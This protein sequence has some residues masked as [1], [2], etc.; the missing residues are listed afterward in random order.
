V[1]VTDWGIQNSLALL[2]KGSLRMEI[3][4]GDFNKDDVGQ[5]ERE[6]IAKMAADRNAI[7]V[8]HVAGEEVFRGSRERVSRAAENAGLRKQV[9]QIIADSHG[10][11]AFEIF[12]WAPPANSPISR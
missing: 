9:I 8:G 5:P 6:H 4:E 7:F 11:P 3:A 10:R 12:R 2:H 1:Y